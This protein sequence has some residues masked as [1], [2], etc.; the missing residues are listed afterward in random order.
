MLKKFVLVTRGR[1]GSTAVLDELG[2]SS[3]LCTTQE[4]FLRQPT[5]AKNWNHYYSLLP[6][7]DLWKQQGGWWKRRFPYYDSDRQQARRYL[8]HAETLAHRKG[9]EG[10]GWKVLSHQFEERPFLSELLERHGYRAIYL[11]RNSVRQ[12]LS[13]MVANQRGIYNSLEKIVDERRYHIEIDRFQWLVR[14]ERECL[15]NDCV[16]LATAGFDF[17]EISYE[18]FCADRHAFYA[19]IFHFLNL[20]ME[21]PPASDFVKV[22]DDPKSVIENYDEVSAAAVALGEAL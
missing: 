21:L 3:R 16:G 5:S 8:V 22:I 10:F 7:F 12:V 18:D 20:P 17:I 2:K 14:W 1:T 19:N 11:R 6:P 15:K 4:L 9:V 13:G